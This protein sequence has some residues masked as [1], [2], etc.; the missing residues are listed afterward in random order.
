MSDN[1]RQCSL[2]DELDQR[3]NEVLDELDN[4]NARIEGLLEECLESRKAELAAEE[5]VDQPLPAAA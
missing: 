5:Q 4:L 2:L 1:P 3:Q